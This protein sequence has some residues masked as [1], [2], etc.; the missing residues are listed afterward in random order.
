MADGVC[1]SPGMQPDLG[2]QRDESSH[3]PDGF[4]A[5]QFRPFSNTTFKLF[6]QIEHRSSNWQVATRISQ[7]VECSTALH[8]GAHSMRLVGLE[9]GA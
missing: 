1:L 8:Q 4:C 7:D 3:L 9:I 2:D 6:K 5:V